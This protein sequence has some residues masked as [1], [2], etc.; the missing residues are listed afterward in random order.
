MGGVFLV[1]FFLVPVIFFVS[2][3]RRIE[4]CHFCNLWQEN[5]G[6]LQPNTPFGALGCC[7]AILFLGLQGV[8]TQH[9]F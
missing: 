4:L 8:E 2:G 9:S 3:W 1:T 6:V 5:V 7:N